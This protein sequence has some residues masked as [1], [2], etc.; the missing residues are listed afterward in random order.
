[1]ARPIL[2]P[3]PGFRPKPVAGPVGADNTHFSD[4][5][6]SSN[7][8]LLRGGA[9]GSDDSEPRRPAQGTADDLRSG[10]RIRRS[11]GI[12]SLISKQGSKSN[13]GIDTGIARAHELIRCDCGA[14]A[15]G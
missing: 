4:S 8:G 9:D 1:M 2:K 15:Q 13:L 14:R 7:D 11:W 6:S 5:D 12:P 10:R 3:R